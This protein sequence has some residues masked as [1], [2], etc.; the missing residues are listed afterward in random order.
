[1]STTKRQRS[2]TPLQLDVYSTVRFYGTASAELVAKQVNRPKR[3]VTG[4]L[5][6]LVDRELLTINAYGF[7]VRWPTLY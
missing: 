5:K 7:A 2:L 3:Q 1:M 4:I 6:H